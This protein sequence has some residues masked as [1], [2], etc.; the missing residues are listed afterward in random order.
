[1]P[2]S[3]TIR[4]ALTARR[5]TGWTGSC[6]TAPPES[7]TPLM[8]QTYLDE[9]KR[10]GRAT[11]ANP[12]KA[13]LSSCLSW[14]MRTGQTGLTI[15]PCMQ[16][17]GV[18]RNPEQGRGRYVTDAEYQSVYV[19]APKQVRLMMELTY[20]TLQRPESDIISW[21]PAIVRVKGDGKV[22]RIEQNKTGRILEIALEGR[23]KELVEQ[24][25]GEV[26]VIGLPI[27]HTRKGEAYTYSGLGAM[28]RRAQICVDTRTKPPPRFT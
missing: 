6:W 26:P 16:A 7:I 13:C 18:R 21:T 23:L 19:T 4:T 9:G 11:R 2:P 25:I 24:A 1:M 15:N 28:L 12:E 22:L 20:R 5:A 8:V 3:T 17:S 14:L 10:A 27:V